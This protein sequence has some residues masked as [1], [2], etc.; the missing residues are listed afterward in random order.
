MLILRPLNISEL[1]LLYNWEQN[2]YD[3]PVCWWDIYF[4]KNDKTHLEKWVSAT[5]NNYEWNYIEVKPIFN[6][7]Q[8]A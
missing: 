4:N 6:A 7:T 1:L 5:N 3:I 8:Q 2:Q